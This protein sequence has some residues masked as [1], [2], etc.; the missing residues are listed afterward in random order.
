MASADPYQD[1]IDAAIRHRDKVLDIAGMTY[2]ARAGP[3]WAQ[4]QRVAKEALAKWRTSPLFCPH[5]VK[6]Q[7]AFL[8]IASPVGMLC[9][10][11][12]LTYSQFMSDTTEDNTCD[13]CRQMAGENGLRPFAMTA[14]PLTVC[15]GMCRTCWNNDEEF[16]AEDDD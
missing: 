7:P 10:G 11:C 6:P 1:Q 13:V 12:M 15:G 2:R 14:G 9:A 3:A 5:L 16:D 4:S 8:P